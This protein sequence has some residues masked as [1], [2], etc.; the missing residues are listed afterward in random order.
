VA[1]Y[2]FAISVLKMVASSSII[3]SGQP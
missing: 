2:S 3:E 1:I